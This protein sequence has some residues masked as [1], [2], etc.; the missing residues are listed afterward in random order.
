MPIATPP[1]DFDSTL[2][3]SSGSFPT[4]AEEWETGMP[5][6]EPAQP[7][8]AAGDAKQLTDLVKLWPQDRSKASWQLSW[9]NSPGDRAV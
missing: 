7:A 5:T 2:M 4:V 9:L 1:P 6:H 3:P 8:P